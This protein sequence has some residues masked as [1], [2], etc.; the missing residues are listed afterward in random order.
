[1]DFVEQTRGWTDYF[2]TIRGY[3]FIRP[4]QRIIEYALGISIDEGIVTYKQLKSENE[5]IKVEWEKRVRDIKQRLTNNNLFVVGLEDE[6][7]NQST[8]KEMLQYGIIGKEGSLAEVMADMKRRIKLLNSSLRKTDDDRFEDYN[9][10]LRLFKQKEQQYDEFYRKLHDDY[11]KKD[12]IAK[13]LVAIEE[14]IDRN[15]NISKVSNLLTS[16]HVRKCPTCHRELD[17]S[18]GGYL[19]IDSRNVLKIN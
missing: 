19:D 13:Q 11:T 1:M 17:I 10:E 12:E 4:R 6:V 3:N 14:E 18:D 16:G 5:R 8:E 2:A 7:S 15:R 9:R